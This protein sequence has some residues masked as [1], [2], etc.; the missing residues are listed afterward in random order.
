MS[1]L[2]SRRQALLA[3]TALVLNPA[4]ARAQDWPAA[5]PIKAIIPFGAGSS[6]DIIARVVLDELGKQLGQTIVVENRAGAAGTI[7]ANAVAKSDPDGY[8]MLV[9]SS[10]HTVTPSTF[11]QLPYNAEADFAA[12]MPLATIPNVVVVNSA[13]G[14]KTLKDLVD[15]AKAKPG[16]LNYASAGAGSA[17]HLTAERFRLS[18]G[19]EAAH[20]PFK[21]S[22]EALT[23][24]IANRM[25]FYCSPINAAIELIKDGRVTALAV[26]SAQRASALPSVPTTIEAG[27][28]DSGYEFW[29]GAFVPR[30]TPKAIVDRLHAELT[31][32]VTS[33]VL[34]KKF[35]DLGADPMRISPSD[36]AAMIKREIA[37][38]ATVVKAA[39]IKAN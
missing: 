36:F 16:T 34:A 35:A 26:S 33:P 38:N 2:M 24:V 12:I 3:A 31:K 4:V 15:A 1:S 19:F 29:I 23:E 25:D 20:V 10:S 8:T 9:N 14:W 11:T 6:T 39:G 37:A 32:A 22:S 30:Q 7:G 13:K 5:R 17:T 21:G 18:A 28:P 27:F